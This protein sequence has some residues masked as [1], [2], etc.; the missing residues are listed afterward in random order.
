M[1]RQNWLTEFNGWGD[2][3]MRV[4]IG[5]N[6]RQQDQGMSRMRINHV[7]LPDVDAKS[8]EVFPQL[9]SNWCIIDSQLVLRTLVLG[10]D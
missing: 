7:S 8:H 2:W 1:L 4:V 6:R 3:T 10:L 9:V 5:G